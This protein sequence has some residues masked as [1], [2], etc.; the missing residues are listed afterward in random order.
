MTHKNKKTVVKPTTATRPTQVKTKPPSG[1]RS[2]K[3]TALAKSAAPSKSAAPAKSATKK[4]FD[5]S[6]DSV[7]IADPIAD[8]RLC[9][10]A[11]VVPDEEAGDLDTEPGLDIPVRD[12]RRLTREL[13]ASF[14]ANIARD[15]VRTPI[16]IAKIGDVATVIEGK[17]RVRAARRA[18][19][20][21]AQQAGGLP[22]MRIRCVVQRDV[23]Q[24]AILA[25][26]IS[27]NNARQ[28]DDLADRVEKLRRY[29][30][31]EVGASEA[32]AAI[33]FNVE[34]RT[35]R[36]WLD[37][38]DHAVDEVKL[39]VAAGQIPA[40]T[41]MELAKIKDP[42]A[43]RAALT[44]LLWPGGG[45][46]QRSARAAR[47]IR[48]EVDDADG[49]DAGAAG[50]PRK[51]VPFGKDA[52]AQADLL[53]YVARAADRA[54]RYSVDPYFPASPSL[55]IEEVTA[56]VQRSQD[57]AGVGAVRVT[58][59]ERDVGYW[60]GVRETLALIGGRNGGD[61][62]TSTQVSPALLRAL[63]RARGGGS[64]AAEVIATEEG[65]EEEDMVW[66]AGT[67]G[68]GCPLDADDADLGPE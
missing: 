66:V 21:R 59:P 28:E 52:R 2:T 8:L 9:G 33:S 29:L 11:G 60:Q 42:D 49:S 19:R 56:L 67:P 12:A 44:K 24:A 61:S 18:N 13:P 7:Y 62:A 65:V 1:P 3:S 23:G 25:T 41:A 35:I 63:E 34:Q 16:V 6:R 53:A 4:G 22:P 5:L 17:S 48:R 58:I 47:A 40:S 46:K 14:L 64:T 20:L 50:R 30:S 45:V 57:E 54:R 68:P 31:P 43:Q 26:M 55:E 37:Y 38:D 27:S 32:D 36:S 10:A 51:P 15:G 39:A